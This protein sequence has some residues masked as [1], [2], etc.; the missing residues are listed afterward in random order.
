MTPPPGSWELLVVDNG[1]RDGTAEVIGAFADRLPVRRVWQPVPG[2]SNAR[3]AGVTESRGRHVV[4]TDDDVVV[5]AGWLAAHAAAFRRRPDAVLFG[6]PTRAVLEEPSQPW[7]RE[8][9]ERLES[10]LAVRDFGPEELALSPAQ[11]PYGLNYAVRGEEQRR[12]LYDPDLGVAPGRRT[13]G[14]EIAVMQALFDEGGTGVWVPTAW[15]DHMIPASRQ[16]EAY[17]ISYYSA[18]AELKPQAFRRLERSPLGMRIGA[19]LRWLRYKAARA[20]G[21]KGWV[22]ALL[23][24]ARFQGSRTA[25][26][27]AAA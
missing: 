16:T 23:Q 18:E 8:E 22:G 11:A 9:A 10:L 3:N 4:W 27:R 21:L 25:I 19:G 14:E 5:H 12:L 24:Y 13:G 17:V 1:S 6:G 2:L 15:V 26:L 7:F 20:L